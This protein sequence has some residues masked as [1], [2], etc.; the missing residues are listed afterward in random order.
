MYYIILVFNHYKNI[1][2]LCRY[3]LYI[4]DIHFSVNNTLPSNIVKMMNRLGFNRSVQ[5]LKLK[6]QQNDKLKQL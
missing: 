6:I 2:I 5:N 3:L 4:I 1:Y